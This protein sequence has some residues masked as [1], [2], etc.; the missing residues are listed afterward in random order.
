MS[1]KDLKRL[2][3]NAEKE[4]LNLDCRKLK[5]GILVPTS[6]YKNAMIYLDT[7]PELHGMY[8]YNE[9]ASRVEITRQPP[10][11]TIGMF[12]KNMEDCD[13]LELKTY[14]LHANN[15]EFSIRILNEA[16]DATARLKA[17]NPVKNYLSGLKWDGVERVHNLLPYYFRTDDSEY[18]QYI[19]KMTMSAACARIDKPGIKYDYMLIIEGRQN[20]GKSLGIERLGSPWY[21]TVSL[22]DRTKDTVDKMQGAWIIEVAEMAAF[23]KQDVE[24]IKAFITNQIDSERLA[25]GRRT[26]IFPRQNVF[27]GTINPD[28]NGYLTDTTGNRRFL[29]IECKDYVRI[30]E[31]MRDKDQL[32]AEAWQIYKKGF[33]MYIGIGSRVEESAISA[34]AARETLDD[35]QEA[36]ADYVRDKDR[37]RSIDIWT[38]CLKGFSSDFDRGRQRRVAD[39]MTR[40]RWIKKVIRID[41][42]TSNGYINP[43]SHDQYNATEQRPWD[44]EENT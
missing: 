3:N 19:G 35:W 37:V 40:L 29:P 33:P 21:R 17:Y 18:A 12:P 32:W 20:L 42:K 24:Q 27:I 15:V 30:D 26:Q 36:I 22:M 14:M 39:C 4:K 11:Q 34:Q 1:E 10:W 31:I 41:G 38:E 25:Y 5:S 43:K 9:F 2:K 23:K 7:T 13:V 44:E 16:I 28:N 6:S 8:Q